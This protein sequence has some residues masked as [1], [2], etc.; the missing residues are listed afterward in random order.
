MTTKQGIG[1]K[2]THLTKP[3]K[4]DEA[5]DPLCQMCRLDPF[6]RLDRASVSGK[7]VVPC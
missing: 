4:I 6:C 3:P 5:E 2:P 1:V 7:I